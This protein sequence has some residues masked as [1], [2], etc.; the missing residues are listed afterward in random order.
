M[1]TGLKHWPARAIDVREVGGDANH[2]EFRAVPFKEIPLRLRRSN[3]QKISVIIAAY[4]E[5]ETIFQVLRTV[6]GHPL[7]D[8]I[9]VVDDGS[10]D[11]TAER[12]AQTSAKIIRLESNGG[13]AGAM[14]AGV[15]AARNDTILFLDADIVGLTHEIITLT[16]SPVLTGRCAMFVA[17]RARHSTG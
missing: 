13:K 17:I 4:N 1:A 10:K 6:E 8:E 2:F 3:Q 5:Q 16:V 9:I 14:D 7:V 15:S 11:G 12:A